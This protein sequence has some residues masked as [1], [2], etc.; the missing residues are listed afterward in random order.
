MHETTHRDPPPPAPGEEYCALEVANVFTPNGDG[1]NEEV[2][3]TTA[4]NVP[5]EAYIMNR[6]GEV[7]FTT[8]DSSVGWDGTTANGK[9]VSEGTYFYSVKAI[10]EFEPVQEIH[11]WI[12]VVR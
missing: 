10:F 3:F 1:M 2:L 6:W 11:G 9:L 4:C 12:T 8:F 7:V 5:I